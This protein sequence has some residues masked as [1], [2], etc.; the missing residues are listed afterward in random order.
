MDLAVPYPGTEVYEMT[1]RHA[2]GYRKVSYDWSQYHEHGGDVLEL[3][4]LSRR[5]L[6]WLRHTAMAGF[7]LRNLR[8]LDLVKYLW[9]HRP[10]RSRA[11]RRTLGIRFVTKERF[12]G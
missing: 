12:T 9:R 2:G 10:L 7:F 4:G 1:L 5:R 8:L 6:R 11:L 3:R